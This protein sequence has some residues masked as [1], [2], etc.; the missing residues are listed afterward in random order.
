MAPSYHK[1]GEL[2]VAAGHGNGK[3]ALLN[4]LPTHETHIEFTPRQQRP[5]LSLAWN[6]AEPNILAMGFEKNKSDHCISIWDIEKGN[7][8]ESCKLKGF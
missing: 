8:S 2:L 6:Q 7:A 4:F 1:D 5:C 3:V